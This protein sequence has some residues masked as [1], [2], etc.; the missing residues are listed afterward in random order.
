MISGIVFSIDNVACSNEREKSQ[1]TAFTLME[2]EVF[3]IKF[4]A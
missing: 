4:G 1:Q 2:D 3:S